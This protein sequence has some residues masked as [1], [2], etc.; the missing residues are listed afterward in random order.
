MGGRDELVRL[1]RNAG[2]RDSAL[3]G[4][5]DDEIR[6]LVDELNADMPPKPEPILGVVEEQPT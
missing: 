4:M 3:I 5:T 1:A 6:S 2:V